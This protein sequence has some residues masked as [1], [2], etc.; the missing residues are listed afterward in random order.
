MPGKLLGFMAA[1]LPVIA[2][3]NKESDGHTIIKEA[4]CGYSINSD[5]SFE[6]IN[7]LV[8]KMLNEKDES[9]DLGKNGYQYLLENYSKTVCI[10]KINNFIENN[11]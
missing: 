4:N 1:S 8:L 11:D 7:S 5:S 6:N 3:L 9:K 10:N 2:F